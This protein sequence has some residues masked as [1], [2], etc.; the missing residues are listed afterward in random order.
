MNDPRS[1]FIKAACVPLD[2]AHISGT[3]ESAEAILTAHP[4]IPAGSIHAAAVVGEKSIEALLR[5]GAATDGVPFPS[6][7][8]E[9]DA[10]LE[11][12][13]NR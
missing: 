13:R 7:Y 5:A 10:L 9:A 2:A 8:P 1:A 6:G 11:S 3:L 12:Q 4:E